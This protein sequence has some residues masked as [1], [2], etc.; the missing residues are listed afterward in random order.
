M[1]YTIKHRHR[2]AWVK[3]SD[4]GPNDPAR[5]GIEDEAERFE[6]REQATME[7]RGF[8]EVQVSGMDILKESAKVAAVLVVFGTVAFVAM[9]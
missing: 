8:E 2:D 9:I 1:R 3:R 4:K 6:S 5:Y 7:A